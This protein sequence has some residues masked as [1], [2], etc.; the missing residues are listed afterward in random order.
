M[1][2]NILLVI[3]FVILLPQTTYAQDKLFLKEEVVFFAYPDDFK[4]KLNLNTDKS[5][6]SLKVHPKRIEDEYNSLLTTNRELYMEQKFSYG[7]ERNF[8]GMNFGIKYD[9][10]ISDINFEHFRTLFYKYEKNKF[11]IHAGYK[12]DSL[13]FINGSKQN[14]WVISPQYNISDN[15]AIKYN[16]SENRIEKT[17]EML[18]SITPFKDNSFNMD[19]GIG[20]KTQQNTD[21]MS[22]R[23]LFSTGIKF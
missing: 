6:N 3:L 12:T 23:F 22:P 18:L 13:A 21:I 8:L 7:K 2:K 4:K 14:G 9:S 16:Y 19:F 11:V 5:T 1:L 10:K 17:S 20:E 15:L